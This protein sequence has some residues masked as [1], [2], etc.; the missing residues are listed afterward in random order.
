MGFSRV[1]MN[2]RLRP[3]LV[4]LAG[5]GA[6]RPQSPG[7]APAGRFRTRLRFLLSPPALVVASPCFI[8]EGNAMAAS[9]RKKLFTGLQLSEYS[10]KD[11]LGAR[12][13]PL[14]GGCRRCLTR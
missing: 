5:P 3:G 10:L 9:T 2:R 12:C 1:G 11:T 14:H 6:G 8:D 4:R 13:P 7:L